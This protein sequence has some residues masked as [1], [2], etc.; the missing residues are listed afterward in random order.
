ME[1]VVPL[2]FTGSSTANGVAAPVR[3]M[4]TAIFTSFVRACS[5]GN[6]N[7]VAQRGNF[8]VCPRSRRRAMSSSLTTTPSVSN[9]ERASLVAPLAAEAST[10]SMP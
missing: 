5:V 10:A 8:A 3:P 6:L 9:G 1:I 7:A 4:F 2:S